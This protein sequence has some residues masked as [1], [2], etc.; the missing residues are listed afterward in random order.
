MLYLTYKS[1]NTF[2]SLIG[3]WSSELVTFVSELFL[4][5][6]SDKEQVVKSEFLQMSFEEGD[7]VMEDKCFT[8]TDLLAEENVSL[9]IP[10]V[11][12]MGKFSPEQVQVK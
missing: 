8:I 10:P 5:S 4:G 11:L 9:N 6:I 3:I 12:Q 1:S 2:K 7:S